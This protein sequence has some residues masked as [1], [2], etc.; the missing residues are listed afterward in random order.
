MSWCLIKYS[1]SEE[2]ESQ[3]GMKNYLESGEN[4]GKSGWIIYCQL[5]KQKNGGR[6][7][8]CVCMWQNRWE[9]DHFRVFVHTGGH[10]KDMCG[11]TPRTGVAV[12][13]TTTLSEPFKERAT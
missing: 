8:V 1:R 10:P 3:D 7:S 4:F 5:S 6:S 2:A 13:V 9:T 12:R 11:T